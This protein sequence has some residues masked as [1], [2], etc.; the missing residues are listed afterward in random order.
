MIDRLV[1]LTV[2]DH[3]ARATRSTAFSMSYGLSLTLFVL[4]VMHAIDADLGVMA[5][6]R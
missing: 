6:T 4:E 5:G 1:A 2:E 3:P